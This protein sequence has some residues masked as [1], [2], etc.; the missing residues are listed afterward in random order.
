MERK[1]I[2]ARF[3]LGGIT[4]GIVD[5]HQ[6][7]LIETLVD[8]Q[9]FDG[10]SGAHSDVTAA[11]NL[12]IVVDPLIRW[13]SSGPWPPWRRPTRWAGC[14]TWT[15]SARTGAASP[16]PGAACSARSPPTPAPAPGRTPWPSG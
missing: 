9:S 13:S 15:C 8:T 5:L 10:A 6:R 3:A 12:A 1:G 4:A 11:A 7:G 14:G 16:P 2:T